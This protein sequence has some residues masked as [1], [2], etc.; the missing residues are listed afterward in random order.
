MRLH[1]LYGQ[2]LAVVG[3]G[4]DPVEIPLVQYTVAVHMSVAAGVHREYHILLVQAP[5]Q[6]RVHAQHPDEQRP[7]H[8]AG[9]RHSAVS[10]GRIVSDE[11][12]C[13]HTGLVA[14]A[15][16]SRSVGGVSGAQQRHADFR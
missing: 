10:G 16:G 15:D 13:T 9:H 1:A 2:L 5:A 12:S 4:A 6:R 14:G 11:R 7:R 3:L 8:A